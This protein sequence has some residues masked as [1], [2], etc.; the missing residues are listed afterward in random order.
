MTLAQLLD[1]RLAQLGQLVAARA[2][3][4]PDDDRVVA[5]RHE[6]RDVELVGLRVAGP[7]ARA[8]D[9]GRSGARDRGPQFVVPFLLQ[10][11]PQQGRGG[12]ARGQQGGGQQRD[13]QGDEGDPQRDPRAT[14]CG[15]GRRHAPR[16]NRN[17]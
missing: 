1:L 11:V 10:V 6:A 13:Q 2:A 9:L 4:F 15:S 5:V 12:E 7:Q 3:G 17:V 8:D 14:R 16:G